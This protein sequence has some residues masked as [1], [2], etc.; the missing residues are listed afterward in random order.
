MRLPPS[1]T[2]ADV[3]A[4]GTHESSG[5]VSPELTDAELRALALAREALASCAGGFASK[6]E[7]LKEHADAS[8]ADGGL[9][10]PPW[11]RLIEE[12]VAM[13]TTVTAREQ[14]MFLIESAACGL[15]L[16]YHLWPDGVGVLLAARNSAGRGP[17]LVADIPELK[18]IGRKSRAYG[19]MSP[20]AGR[21]I[22]R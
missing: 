6:R 2:E 19:A 10:W 12:R 13:G 7:I 20:M 11:L 4:L 15:G 14:T 18:R 16:R 21:A 5:C 8:R 17:D 1:L 9:R 3:A 22:T